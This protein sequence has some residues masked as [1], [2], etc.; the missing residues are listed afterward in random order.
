VKSLSPSVK[1]L[2]EIDGRSS[3]RLPIGSKLTEE[4]EHI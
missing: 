2:R 1:E 3:K 4:E